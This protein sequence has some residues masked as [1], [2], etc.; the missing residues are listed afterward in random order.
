MRDLES[1]NAEIDSLIT[2]HEQQAGRIRHLEKCLETL[3]SP[4]W[5]RIWFRIQ[6]WPGQRNLNADAPG[7]LPGWLRRIVGQ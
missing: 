1:V 5:K 4:L 3:Q 6:R 7:Y 2:N